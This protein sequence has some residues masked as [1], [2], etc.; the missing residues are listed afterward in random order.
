MSSAGRSDRTASKA[1]QHQVRTRSDVV[2]RARARRTIA[3]DEGS[4]KGSLPS[5]RREGLR[6]RFGEMGAS[7]RA[8]PLLSWRPRARR[9]VELR[10]QTQYGESR[11][12]RGDPHPNGHERD[13]NQKRKSAQPRPQRR[14]Q[15]HLRL[16]ARE[17]SAL[18]QKP[19]VHRR[20]PAGSIL[21]PRSRRENA[22]L[23]GV[24]ETS[25]LACFQRSNARRYGRVRA[26]GGRKSSAECRSAHLRFGRRHKTKPGLILHADGQQGVSWV[27]RIALASLRLVGAFC[28]CTILPAS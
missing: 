20:L 13:H 17:A 25:W 28:G 1:T 11:P 5:V 2:R 9:V 4:D 14:L 18:R 21:R 19:A 23:A 24:R 22:E 12:D 3:Q 6:R 10:S 15:W 26:R 16:T 27:G 8:R 7:G